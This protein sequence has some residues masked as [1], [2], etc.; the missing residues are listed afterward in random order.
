MP[1]ACG[2]LGLAQHAGTRGKGLASSRS[3][4]GSAAHGGGSCHSVAL[5][6][7]PRAASPALP[8]P[9]LCAHLF[10]VR[11]LIAEAK[12]ESAAREAAYQAYLQQQPG[13][14]LATSNQQLVSSS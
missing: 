3:L 10:S 12:R 9:H 13:S 2:S 14:E 1:D 5:R 11:R 8:Q 7:A 6:L 4:A